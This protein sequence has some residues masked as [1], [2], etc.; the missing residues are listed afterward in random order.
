[1]QLKRYHFSVNDPA[2]VFEFLTRFFSE[3]RIHRMSEKGG[4][5]SWPETI[6]Y[7]LRNYAQT[8]HIS[9][10]VK[11]LQYNRQTTAISER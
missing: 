2:L 6:Q 4:V 10:A 7:L 1:M 3:A 8:E 5:A 9:Q 11:R